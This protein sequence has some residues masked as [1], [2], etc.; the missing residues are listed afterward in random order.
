[1]I[2]LETGRLALEMKRWDELE[3]VASDLVHSQPGVV[4]NQYLLAM[5]ELNLGR[6]EA[7]AARFSWLCAQKPADPEYRYCLARSLKSAKFVE[8]AVEQARYAAQLNPKNVEYQKFLA[9][10][11]GKTSDSQ[12]QTVS[13][14]PAEKEPETHVI[15]ELE[16]ETEN[17]IAVKKLIS[18][19]D[20]DSST[21]L[22]RILSE[23]QNKPEI[24][25]SRK[26][27]AL[28]EK[29]FSSSLQ[30]FSD[31]LK[32]N[33]I[34]W[35]SGMISDKEIA[36][37]L[38]SKKVK[39]LDFK[40]SPAMIF[41]KEQIDQAGF[42]CYAPPEVDEKK[43]WYMLLDRQ[44]KIAF[45]DV[46]YHDAWHHHNSCVSTGKEG[47]WNFLAGRL[48]LEL[49]QI[50]GFARGWLE[51]AQKHLLVCQKSGY[52]LLEAEIL[53]KQVSAFLR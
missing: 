21:K 23:I 22:D 1:M 14:T 8:Q 29:H 10:L 53:L 40:S 13:K 12:S 15:A 32:R 11:T 47:K 39:S 48:A 24:I 44:A 2:K 19:C 41:L 9:E 6:S 3:K 18:L 33:F 27:H 45:F 20:E 50:D 42:I 28:I 26:W 52:K 16:V 38:K 30:E 37:F 34:L 7:A 51:T 49:W 17:D 25:A 36:T 46:R 4:E 5:A 35:K 31:E 43:P